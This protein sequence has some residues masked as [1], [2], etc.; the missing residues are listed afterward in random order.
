MTYIGMKTCP[1]CDGEGWLEYEVRVVL[2]TRPVRAR[3]LRACADC[4]RGQA[5]GG[6]TR[7]AQR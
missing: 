5:N 6:E 1:V 7:K 4:Q 3:R 2:V